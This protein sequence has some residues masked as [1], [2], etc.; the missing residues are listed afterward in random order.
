VKRYSLEPVYVQLT[1]DYGENQ[2]KMVE[3]S[4][5]DYVLFDDYEDKLLDAKYDYDQLQKR[6]DAL[7]YKLGELYQE[8]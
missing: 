4:K 7:V 6:Y 5:G 8:A 3:N 2:N 1:Y